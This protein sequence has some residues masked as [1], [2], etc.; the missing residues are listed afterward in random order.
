MTEHKNIYELKLHEKLVISEN[1][2]RS[3]MFPLSHA[4]DVACCV[5]CRF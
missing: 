2:S 4:P 3:S 5:D 1:Y